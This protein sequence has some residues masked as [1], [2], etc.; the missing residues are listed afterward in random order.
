MHLILSCKARKLDQ[1]M[2]ILPPSYQNKTFKE[3]LVKFDHI[4]NPLK[5]NVSINYIFHMESFFSLCFSFT[6]PRYGGNKSV[7]EDTA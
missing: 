7:L 2:P 6:H 1:V 4:F 3:I 5:Y